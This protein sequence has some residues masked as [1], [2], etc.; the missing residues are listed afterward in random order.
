MAI[1]P[2]EQIDF[3]IILLLVFFPKWIILAPVSCSCLEVATLIVIQVPLELSPFK[4]QAG[5]F[6][7]LKLPTLPSIHSITPD[8]ST[9]ALFV[10]KL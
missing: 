7:F 8:S 1:P 3:D 9:K 10:T 5:Y 2:L 4:I 6:I